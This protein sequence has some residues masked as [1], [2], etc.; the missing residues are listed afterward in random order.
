MVFTCNHN[1]I[2]LFHF[3]LKTAET[4]NLRTRN[5]M[6]QL[7]RSGVLIGVAFLFFGE[8]FFTPFAGPNRAESW[9]SRT[10]LVQ[11]CK[12]QVGQC[13]TTLSPRRPRSRKAKRNCVLSISVI[14]RQHRSGA[15]LTC[16]IARN[17]PAP[18]KPHSTHAHI[19]QRNLFAALFPFLSSPHFSR[20]LH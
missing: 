20:P 18:C 17:L 8:C 16:P 11:R 2:F 19:A 9:R 7:L 12:L 1:F 5:K 4:D 14:I 13:C 6:L 15:Y 3:L 10:P